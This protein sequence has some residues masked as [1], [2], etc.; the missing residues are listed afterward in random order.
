MNNFIHDWNNVI[1]N[2][3]KLFPIQI[4]IEKNGPTTKIPTHFPTCHI[5][6]GDTLNIWLTLC[7]HEGKNLGL[8]HVSKLEQFVVC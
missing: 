7:P 8:L 6:G 5:F 1:W 2:M 3:L 4:A